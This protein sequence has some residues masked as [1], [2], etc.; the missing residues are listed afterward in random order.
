MLFCSFIPKGI[1]LNDL[2]DKTQ[3]LHDQRELVSRAVHRLDPEFTPHYTPPVLDYDCPLMTK[4]KLDAVENRQ[5]LMHSPAEGLMTLEELKE[6]GRRQME[7]EMKGEIE[8]EN[9][10]VKDDASPTVKLYV[11]C[12]HLFIYDF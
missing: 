11:S 4:L 8:V 1:T 10:D 6:R 5:G 2:L 3:F 9:I 12:F 7:I